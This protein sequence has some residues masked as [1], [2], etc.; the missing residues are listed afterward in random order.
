MACRACTERS[1]Q[2]GPRLI[3][4]LASYSSTRDYSTLHLHSL[5]PRMGMPLTLG[6]TLCQR[7][8]NRSVRE[9][10]AD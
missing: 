7:F 2:E 5:S 8:D 9:H 10:K 3:A 1:L 4:E 6:Q